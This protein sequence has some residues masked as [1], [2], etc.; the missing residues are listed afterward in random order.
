MS[1][2]KD[3]PRQ[4]PPKQYGSTQ[5]GQH[6]DDKGD[7]G[8]TGGMRDDVDKSR[9][10]ID[11]RGDDATGES[12]AAANPGKGDSSSGKGSSDT[13]SSTAKPR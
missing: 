8:K 13:S 3:D 12:S 6:V 9:G 1:Q 11:R 7:K 10:A 4:V 2:E 5:P